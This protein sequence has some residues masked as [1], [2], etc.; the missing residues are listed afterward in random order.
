MNIISFIP[1]FL[2]AAMIA[3]AAVL[4]LKFLGKY[5]RAVWINC[6]I[7]TLP[8][9]VLVYGVG[10]VYLTLHPVSGEEL[11]KL[12]VLATI[13]AFA[14]IAT[15]FISIFTGLIVKIW[16]DRRGRLTA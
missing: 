7:F 14:F 3:M 2:A 16:V 10:P 8:V 11:N 12:V 5:W 9:P 1:L 13:T 15:L 4:H 6:L